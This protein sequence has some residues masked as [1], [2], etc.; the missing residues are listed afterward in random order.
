[1]NADHSL[2]NRVLLMGDLAGY[3]KVA[4]SAMIPVLSAMGAE[5]FNLPTA[6]VSNTLDYGRF[7]ILDTTDYMEGSLR[8]WRELGF[9]FGA[10]Y[11]GFVTSPRQAALMTDF[12]REVSEAGAR[13]FN[14]PIMADHG[15]YYNGMSPDAASERRPLVAVSDLTMP[16][17]TEA[18]LLPGM[19]YC[20]GSI[21]ADNVTDIIGALRA[22][23]ARSVA[24]TSCYVEGAHCVAGYDEPAGHY[25]SI[26]YEV[27][28]VDFPGTGDLF[29]SVTIGRMIQG[30]S[31]TDAVRDAMRVVHDMMEQGRG[32]RDRFKG[33]PVEKYIHLLARKDNE[34][35][36]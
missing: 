6:L 12:C 28:P 10:V 3:G 24:I 32:E 16:N 36:L 15:R 35:K 1:M 4:L 19:D 13:V 8:V 17:Y 33:L 7:R 29:A 34:N 26:P 20:E 18:C 2:D 21:T 30:D 14:D 5:V 25:F 22:I 23:G 31:V 27:L 11:T 9:S